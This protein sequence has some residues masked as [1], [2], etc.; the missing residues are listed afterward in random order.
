ML[1]LVF[2]RQYYLL[3]L[4]SGTGTNY[5]G[6]R[7]DWGIG[8]R[9]A[10]NRIFW[11]KIHDTETLFQKAVYL[12]RRRLDDGYYLKEEEPRAMIS[13]DHG[14]LF[15]EESEELDPF[16]LEAY[17]EAETLPATIKYTLCLAGSET[18]CCVCLQPI[19]K[20]EHAVTWFE[21]QE[22]GLILN[23]LCQKCGEE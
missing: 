23:S 19:E 2:R 1:E 22:E 8:K 18:T 7:A 15:E 5:R 4:V 14:A 21:K 16:L 10:R 3:S 13:E 11:F 12:I 17:Q 6:L 20:G 9:T